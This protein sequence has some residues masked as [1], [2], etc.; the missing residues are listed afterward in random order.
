L[1][2]R[3]EQGEFHNL[4]GPAIIRFS[5]YYN[6]I[7]LSEIAFYSK[8]TWYGKKGP[9]ILR[10]AENRVI[11]AIWCKESYPIIYKSY[12]KNSVKSIKILPTR[13]NYESFREFS[14]NELKDNIN[15]MY[16]TVIEQVEVI[17]DKVGQ[18]WKLTRLE[19]GKITK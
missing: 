5:K 13:N 4:Y 9:A 1:C 12:Y 10:I 2:I 18:G 11:T 17:F 14:P 8:G 15:E 19:I 6:L 3:N 7:Q 16:K